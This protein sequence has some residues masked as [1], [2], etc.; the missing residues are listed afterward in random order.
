MLRQLIL[1]LIIALSPWFW[2]IVASDLIIAA[3]LVIT[4]L[5][6]GF[7]FTN[8]SKSLYLGLILSFG[9]LLLL[10]IQTTKIQSQTDLSNDE[11]RVVDI[12]KALYTSDFSLIRLLIFKLNISEIAEGPVNI[13]IERVTRNFFET[14]DPNVYFFGG[15][16]RER[17]WANDFEKF[18]FIFIFPFLLGI[19]AFIVKRQRIISLMLITT[20]LVFSY[21]GHLNDFGP[22]LLFPFIT[23]FIALGFLESYKF[24]R[25][26][27]EK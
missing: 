1:I 24:L 17:V 18:N 12:R 7:L 14:I 23:L 4:T 27:D 25:K 6:L 8:K 15:H 20:F 13:A 9:L 21:I 16:P 11:Q 10:Q 5:L 22:F 3:L 19:I 2:K 26:T